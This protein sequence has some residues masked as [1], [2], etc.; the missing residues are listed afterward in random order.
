MEGN[1][2]YAV[3]SDLPAGS[4]PTY[5]DAVK[6]NLFNEEAAM[7]IALRRSFKEKVFHFKYFLCRL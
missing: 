3:E 5:A 2:A 4:K 1:S 7:E 6:K